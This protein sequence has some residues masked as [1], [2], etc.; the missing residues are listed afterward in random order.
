MDSLR[1]PTPDLDGFQLPAFNAPREAWEEAFSALR[2]VALTWPQIIAGYAESMSNNQG[3]P[4]IVLL[5]TWCEQ[6]SILPADVA[7]EAILVRMAPVVETYAEHPEFEA[8]AQREM[9]LRELRVE[10]DVLQF[11]GAASWKEGQ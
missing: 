4:D 3:F 10:D 7:A 6:N 5:R 8:E 1:A 11:V 2:S 9:A